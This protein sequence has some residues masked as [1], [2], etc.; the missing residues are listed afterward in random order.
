MRMALPVSPAP[1]TNKPVGRRP[2][3]PGGS[4]S[5]MRISIPFFADELRQ[6]LGKED[7]GFQREQSPPASQAAPKPVESAFVARQATDI[8]TGKGTLI[9]APLPAG[10]GRDGCVLWPP[11]RSCADGAAVREI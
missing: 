3:K 1:P 7:Q 8:G 11:H 9:E 10:N 4:E 6:G 2:R 5:S